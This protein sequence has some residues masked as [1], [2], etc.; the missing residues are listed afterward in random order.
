MI[1]KRIDLTNFRLHKN[2]STYFFRWPELHYRRQRAGQNIHTEAI[3]YLCTTKNFR[4][5]QDSEA[6]SFDNFFFEIEGRFEDI[7]NNKIKIFYSSESNNKKTIFFDDKQIYRASSIIGKFPVVTI[8]QSD[9]SITYGSPGDT[10]KICRLGNI[11]GK[12][13]IFENIDRL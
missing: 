4:D 11:A 12:R 9:Y 10:K 5:A 13:N 7:T 2:T 6:V 1:L 3:Y 8:T